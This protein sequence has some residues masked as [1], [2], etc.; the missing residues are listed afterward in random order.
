[1]TITAAGPQIR[2]LQIINSNAIGSHLLFGAAR[3][4]G[5]KIHDYQRDQF[6]P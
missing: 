6:F 5:F 2:V 4:C 1:V 3:R